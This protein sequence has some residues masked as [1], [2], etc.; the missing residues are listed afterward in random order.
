MLNCKNT[1]P[2]WQTPLHIKCLR[3][4]FYAHGGGGGLPFI[5][6]YIYIHEKPS[7]PVI[8]R[9]KDREH[10]E[11]VTKAFSWGISLSG[12][13]TWSKMD[14]SKWWCEDKALIL[15]VSV[16]WNKRDGV[17]NKQWFC[18]IS[19]SR[20]M[21]SPCTNTIHVMPSSL[22]TVEYAWVFPP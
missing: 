6:V 17:W 21:A 10:T 15:A 18:L 19:T 1:V 2:S 11:Q 13:F 7:T 16:I 20:H 3:V 14:N 8:I 4:L 5:Q 9:V 22:W 12:Y